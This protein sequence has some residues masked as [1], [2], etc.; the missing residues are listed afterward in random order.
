MND[1]SIGEYRMMTIDGFS[2]VIEEGCRVVD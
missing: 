1:L 2:E